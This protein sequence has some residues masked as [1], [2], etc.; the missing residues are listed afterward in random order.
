MGS[1][2]VG[3]HSSKP[4]DMSHHILHLLSPN[5]R[6]RLERS[7]LRIKDNEAGTERSVPLENVAAIVAASPNFD[8]TAAACES[9]AARHYWKYLLPELG[10]LELRRQ[11]G[12][13][14]GVNGMPDYG[15]AIL[16]T[17]CLRSLTAHGF[18]AAIGINHAAK[19]GSF[20]L[21]DDVMEP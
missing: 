7:Q 10:G 21:A 17:A 2:C 11:P 19:A 12:T 13:R 8:I 3:L 6:L 4:P 18:I 5:L 1:I 20:A 16:R 14:E 9:R 15:Y